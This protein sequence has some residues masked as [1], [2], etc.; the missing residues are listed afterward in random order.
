[1]RAQAWGCRVLEDG[2]I[3]PHQI[4]VKDPRYKG[5][6]KFLPWGDKNGYLIDCRYLKGYNTLDVQYQEIVLGFKVNE[7]DASAA[8]VF[9]LM[10]KSGYNEFNEVTDKLKTE[11][12]KIS[13]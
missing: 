10:L 4:D 3:P 13:P 8:E 11:M 1:N 7:N 5:Q 12:L 2:K 6:I 9:Y